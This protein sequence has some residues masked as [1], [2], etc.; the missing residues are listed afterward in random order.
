MKLILFD[1][2]GTL[3]RV[4][5]TGGQ[6]VRD[7]LGRLIGRPVVTDGVRFSGRTD[8]PII[9][10]V[11]IASGLDENEAE[12]TLPVVVA[13]YEEQALE[14]LASGQVNALPRAGEVLSMLIDRD[15]VVLGL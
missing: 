8:F 6:I 4:S 11:L 7:V 2:D 12:E 14:M 13:A 10:Y 5:H 9:R 15:D 1:I 3:L